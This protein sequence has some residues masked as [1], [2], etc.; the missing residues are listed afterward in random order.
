MMLLI[1]VV[2]IGF[3]FTGGGL[4]VDTHIFMFCLGLALVGFIATLLVQLIRYQRAPVQHH[5]AVVLGEREEVVT[6]PR[7]TH[8]YH[9]ATLQTRDGAQFELMCDGGVHDQLAAPDIGVA[10]VK[11]EV[12]VQFVRF[13]D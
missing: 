13:R 5:V 8:R 4:A 10:F 1:A 6:T 7:N 2:P 12:L 11:A 3:A 9:Y